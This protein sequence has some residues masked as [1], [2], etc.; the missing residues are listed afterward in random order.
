M[1]RQSLQYTQLQSATEFEVESAPDQSLVLAA[2]RLPTRFLPIPL[3][4]VGII[5]QRLL[6]QRE[7]SNQNRC[8]V[9]PERWLLPP[10]SLLKERKNRSNAEQ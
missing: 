6:F 7:H 3:D 1:K 2:I 8:P 9:T 10:A 4:A 5:A